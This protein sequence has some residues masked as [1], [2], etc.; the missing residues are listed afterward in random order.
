MTHSF[1]TIKYHSVFILFESLKN[2]IE[3]RFIGFWRYGTKKKKKDNKV[4]EA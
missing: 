4:G 2:A 3:K 1:E